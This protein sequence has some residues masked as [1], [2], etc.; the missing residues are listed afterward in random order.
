M[1]SAPAS[2]TLSVPQQAIDDLR[3]RLAL[4]R[5]PDQAPDAPLGLWYRPRLHAD[6]G[7]VLAGKI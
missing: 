1:A 5:F 3:A 4:T 7:P 6:V 2:F